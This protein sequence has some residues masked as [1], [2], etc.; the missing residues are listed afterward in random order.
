MVATSLS[1]SPRQ[2]LPS[3]SK[4]RR[5]QMLFWL[6]PP[7]AW[8]SVFMILPYAML[9]Y[10]SLGS[11]DYMSFKPG[12]SAANFIRV[13]STEPYVGVLLKSIKLGLIT[14]IGSA[15]LAY[16]VAFC[17]AF[18]THSERRKFQLY[19]LVIVPWWAAYLVKA[20]AWKTILGRDGIIN[21]GLA[22]LGLIERP[23]SFLIYNQTSVALVLIYIFTPFA[24]LSIYA[25]LERIP[26]SI[27]EA[28]A[29]LGASG[30]EIF[31]HLILPL[32]LPGVIAGGIITFSLAFGDFVAPALVG[33]A[34]AVMISNIVIN[35]LGVAFDWPMAAAIGIVVIALGLTLISVSSH[36]EEQGAVRL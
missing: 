32:S 7:L 3:W 29:D 36:F 11:V 27:I 14:A 8:F 2:D 28:A 21:Q 34:D 13:F 1:V 15:I 24:V 5:R 10:Y 16:P 26:T 23:L 22:A 12:L 33:G 31:R 4:N 17:L 20:Y 6:L 30:W 35:L 25:S 9:F 19:L 18:H